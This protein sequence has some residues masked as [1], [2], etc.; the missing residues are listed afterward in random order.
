MLNRNKITTGGFCVYFSRANVIVHESVVV[1]QIQI[2]AHSICLSVKH[3]YLFKT[4]I[5][6]R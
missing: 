2:P 5:L 3:K 6:Q 4:Q 1:I